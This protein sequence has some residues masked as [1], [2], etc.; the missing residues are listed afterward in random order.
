LDISPPSGASVN[1]IPIILYEGLLTGIERR[2]QLFPFTKAGSYNV[3][4]IGSLD[5]ENVFGSFQ[6]YDPWG[7]GVLRPDAIPTA[8]RVAAELIDAR[9]NPER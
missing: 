7:T 1:D 5:I 3:R 8:M 6:D 4:C 9:L 2:I